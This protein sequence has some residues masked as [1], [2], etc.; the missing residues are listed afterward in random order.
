M[1]RYKIEAKATSRINLSL[2]LLTVSVTAFF[3]IINLKEELFYNKI[4]LMQLILA[5]PLLLT[6]TLAYSKIG[7]RDKV[8]RWDLLGWVTFTFGYAFGVNVIGILVGDIISVPLGLIFFAISW[9]LVIIYYFVDISYEKNTFRV[10]ISKILLFILICLIGDFFYF[11]YYI[12]T[13]TIR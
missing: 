3:L 6:S 12:G 8:E 10:S 9:L 5:I 13:L 11:P 7:Y 2:F 4:L 1:K